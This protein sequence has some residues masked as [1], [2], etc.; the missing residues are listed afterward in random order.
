M[1]ETL[2]GTDELAKNL[3][4]QGTPGIVVMPVS[5]ATAKNVT[6]FPGGATESMLQDALNKAQGQAR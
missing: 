5:G 2:S 4:F 1:L 6:V 3:G